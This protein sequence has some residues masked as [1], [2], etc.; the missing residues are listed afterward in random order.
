LCRLLKKS[1]VSI[2]TIYL[3]DE[4]PFFICVIDW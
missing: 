3:D 1:T 4:Y 2:E